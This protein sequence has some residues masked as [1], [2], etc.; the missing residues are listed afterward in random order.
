[1]TLTFCAGGFGPP[2]VALKLRPD[3][4]TDTTAGGTA[5]ATVSVTVTTDGEPCAPVAVTVTCPEYVPAANDPMLAETCNVWGAVPLAGETLNH[6]E[7]LAAV[8][9]SV[10]AP[11][12]ATLT[13]CGEGFGPPCVAL[14]LKPSGDTDK[15]GGLATVRVTV[16]TDGEPCAPPAVTVTCPVYVPAVKDPRLA[17]TCNAWGAVPLAGETLNHPESLAAVKLSVPPPVF[18]MLTLCAEGFVPP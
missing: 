5:G 4:N 1:V 9:L 8:K 10:P 15:T 16:T 2:C 6:A 11:V 17:E 3:G 12:F 7:S 13:L 18:V 14:M